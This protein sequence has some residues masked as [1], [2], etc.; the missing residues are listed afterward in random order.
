MSKLEQPVLSLHTFTQQTQV[1]LS[2]PMFVG[3]LQKVGKLVPSHV[4]LASLTTH[5]TLQH[6]QL[7]LQYWHS[8]RT[9]EQ[10]KR[11]EETESKKSLD[12]TQLVC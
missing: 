11:R 6:G 5:S 3:K 10:K 12:E 4:K 8:N 2:K 7:M 1:Q 9:M